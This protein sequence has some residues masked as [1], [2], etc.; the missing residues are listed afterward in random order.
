MIAKAV[1][2]GCDSKLLRKANF[3][4]RLHATPIISL[5]STISRVHNFQRVDSFDKLKM[6]S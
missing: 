6:Y 4:V 5:K 1:R 2:T 3:T